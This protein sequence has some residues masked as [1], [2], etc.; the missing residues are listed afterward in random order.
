MLSWNPDWTN[1][2]E[3]LFHSSYSWFWNSICF[4][5]ARRRSLMI[6]IQLFA[7]LNKLHRIVCIRG[8]W[9]FIWT[10]ELSRTSLRFLSW[11][12]VAWRTLNPMR[13][14]VLHDRCKPV[15]HSGFL[16]FTKNLVFCC[17][18]IPSGFT[19]NGALVTFVLRNSGKW[20]KMVLSSWFVCWN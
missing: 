3:V 5:S 1:T 10:L 17:Y 2:D 20:V 19:E 11:Y 18:R 16:F 14:Q 12:G 15:M 8:S 7:S 6:P 4:G 9:V 13:R